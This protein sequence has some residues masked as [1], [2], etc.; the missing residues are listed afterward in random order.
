MRFV[1]RGAVSDDKVFVPPNA[2]IDMYE[3]REQEMEKNAFKKSDLN[4]FSRNV[5]D[6]HSSNPND[7]GSKK[8]DERRGVPRRDEAKPKMPSGRIENDKRDGD[9]EEISSDENDDGARH[10]SGET[11]SPDKRVQHRVAQ[12]SDRT[13]VSP[14]GAVRQRRLSSPLS[15]QRTATAERRNPSA[16]NAYGAPHRPSLQSRRIPSDNSEGHSRESGVESGPE[17]VGNQGPAQFLRM[18]GGA[19][20]SPY[21]GQL[22]TPQGL[23][24]APLLLLDPASFYGAMYRPPMMEAAPQGMFPSGAL[25]ADPVT[26]QIMMIP[27]AYIPMGR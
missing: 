20:P 9:A 21:F 10:G 23:S 25:T 14:A 16:P 22:L 18:D 19:F 13:A 11:I 8:I 12:S 1:E 6:S 26:G 27:E 7:E 3:R 17:G 24:E 4:A 15:D 5:E 2:T